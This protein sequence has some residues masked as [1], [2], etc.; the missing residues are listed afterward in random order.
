MKKWTK[1]AKSLGAYNYNA[2]SDDYGRPDYD[3]VIKDNI[4]PL[5]DIF[6]DVFSN[7]ISEKNMIVTF[8][9]NTL[10]PIPILAY[11]YSSNYNKSTLIF[12]SHHKGFD[13][14]SLKDFHN[15]NYCML[16]SYGHFVNYEHVIGSIRKGLL[17]SN[18]KFP[19]SSNKRRTKQIVNDL[20]NRLNDDE[21]K[22]L[23]CTEDNLD[24]I[25]NLSEIHIGS[26]DNSKKIHDNLIDV[27]LVIFENVDLYANSRYTTNKF[28]KWI[29][30]YQ[31]RGIK[32]LFHFSNPNSKFI[33]IIKNETNSLVVPFNFD[34]INKT[35][36]LDKSK[37]YY[38]DLKEYPKREAIIKNYN[39][40]S[41]SFFNKQLLN[42]EHEKY[43]DIAFPLIELGNF[44]GYYFFGKSLL[45]KINVN[46]VVNKKLFLI[47]KKLFYSFLDLFINPLRL[48]VKF[49]DDFTP[50]KS[51]Q[52]TSFLDLFRQKLYLE[53]SS[54]IKN[55]LDNFIDCLYG[56][57]FELGKSKH[58]G[59]KNS[60]NRLGKEYLMIDIA[61]HKEKYFKN[62]KNLIICCF[63][64]MEGSIIKK[65]LD[66]FDVSGV[67]VKNIHWLNKSLLDNKEEYNL[68]LPGPLP[69]KYFSE[70]F[71]SYAKILILSYEGQNHDKISKQLESIEYIN[72]IEISNSIDY[73]KEVCDHLNV[74]DTNIL[75]DLED[76]FDL[77]DIDV[78][79]DSK[80]E[81]LSFDDEIESIIKNIFKKSKFND[82]F[83]ESEKIEQEIA[84][85]NSKLKESSIGG[86]SYDFTLK[87]I[88]SGEVIHKKLLANKSYNYFNKKNK[89]AEGSPKNIKKG[90]FLI[91]IDNDD[92]KSLLELVIEVYK[93]SGNNKTMPATNRWV[94]GE[95]LGPKTAEDLYF[96]GEL[97]ND[98][99][100]L[101]NYEYMFDEIEKI[102][103]IH[104]ITGRRLNSIIKEIM[105][106]KRNIQETNLGY[107]GQLFYEKLENGVYE[108]MEKK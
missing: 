59:E 71:M 21:P 4:S 83:E 91:F 51:Y 31:E 82:D 61:I 17:S 79:V 25:N 60:F 41:L 26:V 3:I 46:E 99:T 30:E 20:N 23:L 72:K 58:Y 75:A 37:Q 48:K 15:L 18:I 70:L 32:F 34:L 88:E 85:E 39:L 80:E 57:A 44:N 68:L 77:E 73:I 56:I 89:L 11:I 96:I 53:E 55:L 28:L 108:V 66:D 92:K 78:N 64:A 106:G 36:L 6:L 24:I 63:N 67:I 1:F 12:T 7:V 47:S 27:G 35:Y 38:A 9:D 102:R 101:E 45:K 40:D 22:I 52:L 69:L 43:I 8:P 81:N 5:T 104:R 42:D 65:Q 50:F 95:A 97:L 84:V 90:D 76:N 94:K 16:S 86:K 93:I 103:T 19:K 14:K 29:R 2:V 54:F 33:H 105:G 74:A 100:I 98:T 49:G 10:R 87:N 62:N 107:V 13:N